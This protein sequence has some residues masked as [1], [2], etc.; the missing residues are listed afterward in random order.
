[1]LDDLFE[2]LKKWFNQYLQ[3][4]QF[5]NK[6]DQK[7]ID[8]KYHHS[9]RVLEEIT[10]LARSLQ[11]SKKEETI[12][13]II[14][15]FHDV[16]R[17]EQY[18]CYQ[19]FSDA[20]SL[21][22]AELGVKILIEN[23]LLTEFEQAL[24]QRI[25]KAIAYH[26]KAV[27]PQEA[28]AKDPAGLRYAQLIRDADKLDIWNIFVQRYYSNEDN[29][30]ISHGLSPKGGITPEIYEKMK[31]GEVI[32]YQRLQTQDDLKLMQMG[33][34]YDLNFKASLR[35]VKKRGYI[36]KIYQSM[37]PSKEAKEIYQQIVAYLNSHL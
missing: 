5:K 25:I 18:A 29:S 19:T 24:R 36:D 34:I 20:R 35:T 33:W 32:N 1:M 22:H 8:L 11:L 10:E 30:K 23:N 15:L 13:Q 28:F 7:Q 17:F 37:S 14:G 21:D 12:T 4:Y 26:N 2:E 3:R 6:E 16:G 31:K 27:I 9:Y